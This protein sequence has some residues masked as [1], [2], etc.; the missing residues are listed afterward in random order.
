[1]YA[2]CEVIGYLYLGCIVGSLVM[3]YIT[4]KHRSELAEFYRSGQFTKSDQAECSS[5]PGQERTM[6]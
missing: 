4:F 6:F 3:F 1:M 2:D 5:I